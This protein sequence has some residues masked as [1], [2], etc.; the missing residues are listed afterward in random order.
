MAIEADLH[1]HTKYSFDCLLEPRTVIKIAFIRGL[2]AIAITDHNTVKG[3][4][5]AIREASLVEN[6]MVIPGIEVKTDMGDLIGLYVQEEIKSR[7][8]YDAIDEIRAQGGLVV[9]PH[10]YRGHKGAVEELAKLA[11][12]IEAVN[13]RCSH[14]RNA[15]VYKLAKEM[16][17]P[18]VAGSDAH[19]AF[20]IGRV[21]TKFYSSASSPEELRKEI[22]SCER[23]LVGKESP[24]LVHG[25]TFAIEILKRITGFC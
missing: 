3:S 18:A 1:I 13:G 9:L 8:F 25:L 20:E 7:D 21:K 22:L 5:T 11:D 2:S 6:L 23:E 14:A 10:P 4:L 19:F 15:R 24:F 12:L 16:G 17:K